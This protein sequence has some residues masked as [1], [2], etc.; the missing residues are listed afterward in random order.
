MFG[1]F[2]ELCRII[3]IISTFGCLWFI[4]LALD[5]LEK[6]IYFQRA[7]IIIV[8]RIKKRL[9]H[10]ERWVYSVNKQKAEIFLPPFLESC[11]LYKWQREKWSWK[12]LWHSYDVL[13]CFPLFYFV[14]RNPQNLD[15]YKFGH[16]LG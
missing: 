11:L 15:K 2:L 9:G 6:L 12:L 13:L 3:S 5:S 8:F 10:L 14:Y 4:A 1:S 16:I 7:L